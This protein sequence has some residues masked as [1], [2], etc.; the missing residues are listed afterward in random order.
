M[1]KLILVPMVAALMSLAACGD[2]D[3]S[4]TVTVDG[5]THQFTL[6][7]YRQNDQANSNDWIYW[8]ILYASNNSGGN[9]EPVGYYRSNTPVTNLNTANFTKVN[10]GKL[11]Q[12]VEED[13]EHSEE[14]GEVDLGTATTTVDKPATV[15][16]EE[17]AQPQN[18]T[19]ENTN[20]TTEESSPSTSSESSSSSDSGSSGGGDD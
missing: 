14:M 3:P 19:E 20:S 4:Q 12:E 8:Y 10:N 5:S 17:E 9:Y 2:K 18:Q 13:V 15:Q 6:H 1:R 16:E 7:A 11:P